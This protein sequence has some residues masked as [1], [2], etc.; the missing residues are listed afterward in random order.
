MAPCFSLEVP[1]SALQRNNV[2]VM[3]AAA[4]PM[5]FA[6]GYG[7]DQHMWRLIAP[8]F[9]DTHQVVLFDHVGAGQSDVSAY[10]RTKYNTLQ[11]YADDMLEICDEL[12][13]EDAV[14]VGHSVSAMI[15]LLAAIKQPER[16]SSLVLI[17]PS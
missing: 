13:L 6:H 9:T 3:G 5:I 10:S 4:R 7:C 11:A 8:A 12:H 17:G 14:F 16:F 15:G 1:V 2:T